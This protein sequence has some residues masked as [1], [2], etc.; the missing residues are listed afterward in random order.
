MF[1]YCYMKLL[2]E[3]GKVY[4]V[5]L[6]FYKVFK[7]IGKKLVIEYVWIDGELVEVI[8]KVGKGYMF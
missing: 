3:V 1:F 7:G 4:I 2:I 8:D 5:L 6:L